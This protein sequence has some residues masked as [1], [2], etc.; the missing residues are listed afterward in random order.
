MDHPGDMR[1]ILWRAGRR[2][3]R[4]TRDFGLFSR[5]AAI[6]RRKHRTGAQPWTPNSRSRQGPP[7]THRNTK[8]KIIHVGPLVAADRESILRTFR[9]GGTPR[10][11]SVGF[12]QLSLALVGNLAVVASA[13]SAGSARSPGACDAPPGLRHR[14]VAPELA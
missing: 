11:A 12:K 9:F 2:A 6:A 1:S 8:R 14:R 4:R 3:P 7:L 5:A 10:A 13:A